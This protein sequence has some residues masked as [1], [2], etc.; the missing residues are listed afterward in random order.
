M[1]MMMMMMMMMTIRT[2]ELYIARRLKS[3]LTLIY[4]TVHGLIALDF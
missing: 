3:D 4:R 1:M 2:K